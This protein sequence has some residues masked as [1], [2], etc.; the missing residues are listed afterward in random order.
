[1]R[2]MLPG[3]LVLAL[4]AAGC[5]N[6]P[7]KNDAAVKTVLADSSQFTTIQWLDSV[8]NFGK[9]PE[10]QKLDVSF[11]FRNTGDKPLVVLRVQ[12]SCGCTAP[13]TLPD[14][15]MPGAEGV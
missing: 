6:D 10:G 2:H 14:P 15:I 12:P 5:Q 11:R 9:I 1:M 8:S 3:F 7:V 13:S 4:F